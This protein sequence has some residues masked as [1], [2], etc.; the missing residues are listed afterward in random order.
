VAHGDVE[1]AMKS[2]ILPSACVLGVWIG[3]MA[4]ALLTVQLLR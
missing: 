1:N 3:A 4:F 2:W